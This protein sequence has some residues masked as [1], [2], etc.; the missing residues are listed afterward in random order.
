MKI[1]DLA[2]QNSLDLPT[3]F[4]CD[5]VITF[6]NNKFDIPYLNSMIPAKSIVTE[7]GLV[8]FT[9]LHLNTFF[10]ASLFDIHVFVIDVQW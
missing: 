4:L 3:S 7:H 5:P 9:L 8:C 6:H 2:N 10:N 1:Y